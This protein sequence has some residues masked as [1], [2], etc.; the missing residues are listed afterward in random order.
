MGGVARYIRYMVGGLHEKYGD[1]LAVCTGLR[2]LPHSIRRIYLPLRYPWRYSSRPL[3]EGTN[4]LE[5]GLLYSIEKGLKP[6]VIFSPFYG[7]LASLTPQ[8]FT[9]YDLMLHL[10]PEH[11]DPRRR[12]L[13][14][15]HMRRCFVN[16]AAILCISNSTK[17]DLLRLHPYLDPKKLYVVPLGVSELFFQPA[18]PSSSP[19][20]YFLFVGNRG[21]PK[22]FHRLL[23]AYAISGLTRDFDLHVVSPRNDLGGGWSEA[24]QS[25][26]RSR[27]LENSIRLSIRVSDE[28]LAVEYGGA[29]AFVYPS[30]YEGFGL[31][32]LEAFASGTVVACSRTSSLPEA[33]GTAAFYFDPL[34]VE[35]MVRSLTKIVQV[36]P[37]ERAE[38]IRHGQLHARSLSWARCISKTCEILDSVASATAATD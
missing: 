7:P 14:L 31:P 33:G 18:K 29:A 38:R 35:S 16:A 10:Y 13:Q 22:N 30:E 3:Y 36:T 34:D 27:N 25:F 28:E 6:A 1:R 24:E 37:A 4:L 26:I 2:Q 15:E 12:R 23:E 5:K 17:T 11:F 9:V 32:V 19:R 8:V 21:G 20:P